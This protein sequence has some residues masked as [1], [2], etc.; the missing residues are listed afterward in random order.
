MRV[1]GHVYKDCEVERDENAIEFPYGPDLRA[2]PRKKRTFNCAFKE[3]SYAE[4]AQSYQSS[5]GYQVV[6]YKKQLFENNQQ[7]ETKQNVEESTTESDLVSLVQEMARDKLDGPVKEEIP[8]GRL[9]LVT[10]Q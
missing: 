8:K 1:I 2:S 4:K 3:K 10:R 7:R 6:N 5:C 9:E